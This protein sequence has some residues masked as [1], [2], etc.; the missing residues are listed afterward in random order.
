[1][2]AYE[3]GNIIAAGEPIVVDH[4]LPCHYEMHPHPDAARRERQQLI[5]DQR[6]ALEL[7][8][9]AKAEI[10]TLV[11]QRYLSETKAGN[12]ADLWRNLL[13]ALEDGGTAFADYWSANRVDVRLA[14]LVEQA[15]TVGLNE[16]RSDGTTSD[17]PTPC[18]ED[19]RIEC[20]LVEFVLQAGWV[21]SEAAAKQLA[22]RWQ[23]GS[24]KVKLNAERSTGKRN[25]A[26]VYP[27]EYLIEVLDSSKLHDLD[28]CSL[29]FEAAEMRDRFAELT[30]E[31]DESNTNLRESQK[32]STAL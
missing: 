24:R 6:A 1:M 2:D 3:C 19:S 31:S 17:I 4:L 20:T 10:A 29:E 32:T 14:C 28:G 23:G 16:F 22:K 30:S 27:F 8:E 26:R 12:D 18:P 5:D 13:I 9:Q 21:E 7:Y 25:K 15:E 11:E